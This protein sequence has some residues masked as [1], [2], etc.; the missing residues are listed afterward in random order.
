[1]PEQEPTQK[2]IRQLVDG[3]ASSNEHVRTKA[4]G[5][6]G[7]LG[8]SITP[9][10]RELMADPD[11]GVSMGAV[12]ALAERG[13]AGQLAVV[14]ALGGALHKEKDPYMRVFI[15]DTLGKIGHPAVVR[16]LH[17]A[18]KDAN[19]L[20]AR[21]AL[22]SLDIVHRGVE[23]GTAEHP[24]SSTAYAPPLSSSALVEQGKTEHPQ[25]RALRM[26]MP[27]LLRNRQG[28]IVESPL[29]VHRLLQEVWQGGMVNAAQVKKRLGDMRRG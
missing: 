25:A 23:Q 13:K 3:L 7:E 9:H 22:Q 16:P 2:E 18:L 1:M 20:V 5:R 11:K 10:L 29:L 28:V 24:R 8:E 15:A 6:L 4:Q 21:Q 19:H 12:L 17:Q 26:V 14:P 27:H